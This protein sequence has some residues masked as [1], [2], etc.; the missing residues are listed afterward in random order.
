M[1]LHVGGTIFCTEL[2]KLLIILWS[3]DY[4]NGVA[5]GGK[6]TNFT[7]LSFKLTGWDDA[8]LR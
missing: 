7:E 2:W 6:S 4:S 1:K 3:E 5:L 8:I